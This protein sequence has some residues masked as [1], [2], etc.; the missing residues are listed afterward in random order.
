M[1]SDNE[2]YLDEYQDIFFRMT[3]RL[4]SLSTLT[5]AFKSLKVTRKKLKNRAKEA[6][7]EDQATFVA[8]IR[9]YTR[10]QLIFIDEVNFESKLWL[11]ACGSKKQREKIWE[12]K[13]RIS[14]NS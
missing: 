2:L 6:K 4:P 1:E 11:G 7:I 14:R 13:T 3:N 12:I 5:R 8:E 10:K 9:K